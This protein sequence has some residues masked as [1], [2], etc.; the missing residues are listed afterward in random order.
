L[1]ARSRKTLAAALTLGAAVF[2]WP[3]QALASCPRPPY[4]YR[5]NTEEQLVSIA[6]KQVADAPAIFKGRLVEVQYLGADGEGY[7]AFL[8]KY[9]VSE[10]KKG[11]GARYARILKVEWCDGGCPVKASIAEYRANSK[12]QLFMALPLSFSAN[13]RRDIWLAQKTKKRA[14]GGDLQCGRNPIIQPLILESAPEDYQE[15]LFR[16][17]LAAELEKLPTW[18]PKP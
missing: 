16:I 3:A 2:A 13:S 15:Y 18:Q 12:E 4:F 7:T 1:K 9:R 6:Q 14:D 5:S 8:M 10:W 11:K 17:T